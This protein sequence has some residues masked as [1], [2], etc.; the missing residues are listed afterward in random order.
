MHPEGVQVAELLREKLDEAQADYQRATNEYKR[1]MAMSSETS[2]LDDPA[3]VD[4]LNAMRRA[5]AIHKQARLNYEQALKAF[6]DFI[7]R[8][9]APPADPSA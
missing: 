3:L 6:T 7:L 9:K 4:G 5:M 8:G 2:S 1:L